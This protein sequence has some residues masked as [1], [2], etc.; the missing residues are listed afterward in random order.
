MDTRYVR[1]FM[2][3]CGHGHITRQDIKAVDLYLSDLLVL[4]SQTLLARY[5][6]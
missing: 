3:V 6:T 4:D 5:V 2:Y 1:V